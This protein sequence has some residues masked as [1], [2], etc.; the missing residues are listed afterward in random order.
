[1][2]IHN[3]CFSKNKKIIIFSS[4]NYL[5]YSCEKLQY[6]TWTCFRNEKVIFYQTL[7]SPCNGKLKL[8]TN[9]ECMHLFSC[10]SVS[11]LCYRKFFITECKLPIRNVQ[12][13]DNFLKSCKT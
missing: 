4:E 13:N 5:F 9:F 10:N 7:F 12:S 6:I 8:K 3:Q 2:C 11:K 1:M